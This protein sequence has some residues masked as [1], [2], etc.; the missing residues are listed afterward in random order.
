[1]LADVTFPRCDVTVIAFLE[2]ASAGL[3]LLLAFFSLKVIQI[4]LQKLRCF[5]VK[6]MIFL[7]HVDR[8]SM[9][10]VFCNCLF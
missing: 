1:M 2:Y 8:L 10:K 9:A 7:K 4:L 6:V 3:G 5:P